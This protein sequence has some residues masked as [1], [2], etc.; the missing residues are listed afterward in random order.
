L[1]DSAQETIEVLAADVINNGWSSSYNG[2]DGVPLFS[3]AHPNVGGGT[4]GNTPSTQADLSVTSLQ[5][6]LQTIEDMTDER[7]KKAMTKAV[8]LVVPTGNMWTAHELLKSEYKPYVG[9]NEVN[10]LQM[11]DLT[12]F[13]YH[14]MTDSD[15]WILLAQKSK[16]KIK[17]FWR[18]K[19]GAL[20]RG[21]DFDSTNLK[22]LA[23]FRC[24]AD[25][26]HYIGTYGSQ[27]A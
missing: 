3:T 12:Y 2:P 25:F 23:R 18:V 10:A 16:L 20:R 24:D 9:N 17:F 8:L 19:P 22:H 4:Q 1:S 21:T 5:A 15:S 13:I 26:S 7:G 27:G 6:A 14:Y 11:K